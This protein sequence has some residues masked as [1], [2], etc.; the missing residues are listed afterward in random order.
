M[1]I[2]PGILAELPRAQAALFS[3]VATGETRIDMLFDALVIT[4]NGPKNINCGKQQYLGPYIS[5]LNR[6]LA[7]HKLAVKPGIARASYRLVSL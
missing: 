3:V 7:K 2:P 4:G 6:R 5:K 1:I